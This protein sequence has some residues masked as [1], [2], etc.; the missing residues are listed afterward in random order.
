MLRLLQSLDPEKMI[1]FIVTLLNLDIIDK[2]SI[3]ISSPNL[4]LTLIVSFL[5]SVFFFLILFYTNYIGH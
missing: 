5:F 1:G 2:L 4:F 3:S